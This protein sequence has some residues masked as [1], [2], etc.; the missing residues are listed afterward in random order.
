MEEEFSVPQISTG[1]ILREAVKNQTLLGVQAK[2]YMDKG[3]LVPDTLMIELMRERLQEK[4]AA[5]GYI[6]DGFP[7]TRSQADALEKMLEELC[8]PLDSVIEI[9]VDYEAVVQRIIN[10]RI[11][12]A[13]GSNYNLIDD[14]PNHDGTCRNCG[15]P[16]IQRPD[17]NEETVR[18]RLK[19]YEEQTKPLR[20]YYQER[21]LLREVDG[22]RSIEEVFDSILKV[23]QT[24]ISQ[25]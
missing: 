18:T 19:V 22:S 8:S 10:R 4:S 15:E 24:S 3:E 17:D 25:T 14:P 1:D 9:S 20:S 5:N 21:G 11:C 2:S 13:C 16:V 12:P 7:R 23:L 6:L